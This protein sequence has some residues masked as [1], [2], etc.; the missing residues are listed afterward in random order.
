MANYAEFIRHETVPEADNPAESY[1]IQRSYNIWH[2][3]YEDAQR[4]HL[5]LGDMKVGVDGSVVSFGFPERQPVITLAHTGYQNGIPAQMYVTFA[6]LDGA[7]AILRTAE[8]TDDGSRGR[9]WLRTQDR[10]RLN[11][12]LGVYLSSQERV[13]RASDIDDANDWFDKLSQFR[14]PQARIEHSD[15]VE[16][17]W[18]SVDAADDAPNPPAQYEVQRSYNLWQNLYLDAL[19]RQLH[20]DGL[21]IQTIDGAVDI[22]FPGQLPFLSLRYFG[23]DEHMPARMQVAYKSKRPSE[24]GSS[25]TTESA[26]FRQDDSRGMYKLGRYEV[27]TRNRVVNAPSL[28][29]TRPLY[30]EDIERFNQ[31]YFG[32]GLSGDTEFQGVMRHRDM[33]NDKRAA[34]AAAAQTMRRSGLLARLLGKK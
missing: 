22:A 13:L 25:V 2:G 3:L 24:S 34:G 6:E 15:I 19:N 29:E 18:R 31:L 26:E 1:D 10:R 27:D 23:Q 14:K 20:L 12:G 8:F 32:T 9:Y 30:A 21:Q 11:N 33:A 17:V 28:S 4:G 5:R 16:P 7:T